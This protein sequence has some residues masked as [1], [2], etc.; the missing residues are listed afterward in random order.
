MTAQEALY[1]I[2]YHPRL[3]CGPAECMFEDALSV[4][5][6]IV[7]EYERLSLIEQLQASIAEERAKR[8]RGAPA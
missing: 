1:V 5:T 2:E 8:E 3:Y 4:L 7:R 6:E